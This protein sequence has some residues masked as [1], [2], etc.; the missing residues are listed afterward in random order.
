MTASLDH[1]AFTC[2]SRASGIAAFTAATGITLPQSGTHPDMGTHNALSALGPDTFLELI[3]IDP[4]GQKP[5]RPRWFGLDDLPMDYP[6]TP[7]AVILRSDDL[8]GDL[9]KGSELGLDL[10][11]PMS[12]SRGNLTWKFAVRD[13]GKI[14]QNGTAPLLMQW[15]AIDPHPAANMTDH[16]LRLKS[17]SVTTPEPEK[18]SQLCAALGWSDLTVLKGAPSWTF[19]LDINGKEV[20]L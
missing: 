17:I 2:H 15:D 1:I 4:A 16:G 12:L 8:A 14:H 5:A 7:H 10:G 9:R 20:A 13:D 3:T 18:L 6:L 11:T 19:T